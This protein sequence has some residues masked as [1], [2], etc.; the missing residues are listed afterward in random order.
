M[1]V[2]PFPSRTIRQPAHASQCA[3][4][5][6]IIPT[7]NEAQSIGPL[8]ERLATSLAGRDY[9]IVIV[10]DWSGDGTAEM[11]AELARGQRHIRLIRRFGRSGLSS[12]VIEGALSTCAEVV[13]VFDADLQHDEAVLSQLID[14]V[15]S[16]STDL[17]IGSR[18]V[19]GGSCGAWRKDR[20]A[21]SR[22]GTWLA[23]MAL[24]VAVHD[25]MSGFFAMR[26][27]RLVA[28]VPR[29]RGA[30]FKLLFDILMASPGDIRVTEVPYVF[31]SRLA[32]TSKLGPRVAADY[33]VSVI[34][35]LIGRHLAA[36]LAAYGAIGLLGLGVHLTVLRLLLAGL[37]VSFVRAQAAAVIAA[38][39]FN[40][41]LNNRLTFRDRALRGRKLFA[42]LAS[43]YVI[44]GIGAIANVGVG[45]LVYADRHR[46]WLA[47]I[48]G[49]VVGSV[50]NFAA[51][52]TVTWRKR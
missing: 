45:S 12:A 22:A 49:A 43:F 27:D 39:G 37:D 26:A 47:G 14:L 41:T 36:R 16:G 31:R 40:F 46:W 23:A 17:A 20:A 35:G 38:I 21:I 8:I 52:A 9:E 13:A 24:P 1:E 7:L 30:G 4:L 2:V 3:R 34:H 6:I 33:A 29:L 15:A 42:G 50:W 44:C 19:A 48:A 25:P 28:L 18:Y 51:A 11:V 5:A 32:G 10:D